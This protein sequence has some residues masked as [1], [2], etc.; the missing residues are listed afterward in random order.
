MPRGGRLMSSRRTLKKPAAPCSPISQRLPWGAIRAAALFAV[1]FGLWLYA[2]TVGF[3]QDHLWLPFVGLVADTSGWIFRL[4]GATVE[5]SAR[6]LTVNGT[7]LTIAFGCDGLEAHGIFIAALLAAALPWKRKLTGLLI[8]TIGIF[9]INQIRVCG[10]FLVAGIG[11]DWF[12]YAHTVVGQTFVIVATMA[13]FLWWATRD[14]G[15]KKPKSEEA[16]A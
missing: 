15:E 13:L 10:I 16:L 8:G 4:F 1:I 6:T 2:L 5:T 9:L 12:Y 11:A 3:L 7:T 14:E